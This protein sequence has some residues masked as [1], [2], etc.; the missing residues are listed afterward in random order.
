M[1]DRGELGLG[2]PAVVAHR[3]RGRRL[4]RRPR[5][6]GGRRRGADGVVPGGHHAD[7][8]HRG[9]QRQHG[10]D[11]RPDDGPRP[12]GRRGDPRAGRA[13][14]VRS[15]HGESGVRRRD[16]RPV[17]Q[18]EERGPGRREDRR[19]VGERGLRLPRGPA[20]APLAGAG[21]RPAGADLPARRRQRLPAQPSG[22]PG[23]NPPD[24]PGRR[25]PVDLS[26]VAPGSRFGAVPAR[27]RCRPGRRHAL[28]PPLQRDLLRRRLPGDDARGRR[29]HAGARR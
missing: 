14:A 27:R 16:R 8:P 9:P 20:R 13:A 12:P 10:P 17:R 22:Q 29:H 1:C 6:R 3:A 28:R 15:R 7:R 24:R 5:P 11:P 4:R 21:H 19:L 2:A 18:D 26:E 25:C 23:R